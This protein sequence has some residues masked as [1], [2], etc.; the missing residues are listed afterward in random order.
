MKI[1]LD[2]TRSIGD[3][4]GY[5]AVSTYQDFIMLVNAFGHKVEV[6]SLD[7]HL[8]EASEGNGLDALMYLHERGI[9]PNHINIHSSHVF[10]APKMVDYAEK[11]F[12]KSTITTR[13]VD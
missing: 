13:K 5:C 11:H 6:V 7:Y 4:Y 8:G 12:P 2:D 9:Y 3:E 10:G 1:F